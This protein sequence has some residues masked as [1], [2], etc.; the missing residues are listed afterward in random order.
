MTKFKNLLFKSQWAITWH[1]AYWKVMGT[2]VLKNKDHSVIKKEMIV[3]SSPTQRYDIFIAL[4]KCVYWFKLVSQVSDAVH[5]PLNM[6][7]DR[8]TWFMY[9]CFDLYY[10]R[11]CYWMKHFHLFRRYASHFTLQLTRGYRYI[12]VHKQIFVMSQ[13]EG[14]NRN[15]VYKVV[16][17]GGRCIIVSTF[18]H[19][20]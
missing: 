9:Y 17:T 14:K 15:K 13:E 2:Q 20:L 5:G 19:V 12:D 4:R 1:K 10:M 16:L 11:S 7:R 6:N 18:S 3:F 8:D